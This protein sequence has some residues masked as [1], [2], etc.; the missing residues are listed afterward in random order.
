MRVNFDNVNLLAR[1]GPNTFAARLAKGLIEA[2]HDVVTDGTDADVSLVFIEPSGRSLAPKVIQRLDGIWFRPQDFETKNV[3]I[4]ALYERADAVVWQSKFDRGMTLKH[5]GPPGTYRDQGC[6]LPEPVDRIIGNGVDLTRV[7]K[8]TIPELAKIRASY[9]KVFVCSSNWHPQKRLKANIQ[10]FDHLR[11][12]QFP[13]SCLFIMGSNPDVMTT[14]PHVFYTGSQPAEVYMQVFAIAD[15]MLHLA[16]A[17]HC[18]NVVVEA[19]SQGTPVVCSEVGG[20]KELIGYGTY[21]MVLKEATYNYEL[22]DYDHPPDIDVTQV[23][24]LPM[25]EQ[26]DYNAIPSINIFDVTSDYVDL[27][28]ELLK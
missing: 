20:T 28:Q 24:F 13:N 18:P 23:T 8:V 10:L 7:E 27:F 15:W 11:K 19:L 17:D 22:A 1:T 2:G 9:D 5:W 6:V 26:L 14:D 25:R 21:G 4:K 16:W 3:N 12:T